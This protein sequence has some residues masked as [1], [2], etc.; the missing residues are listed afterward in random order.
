MAYPKKHH[1]GNQEPQPATGL[2]A[3]R[4]WL[5]SLENILNNSLSSEEQVRSLA[6][7]PDQN[8]N[9]ILRIN[10]DGLLVYANKAS[11]ILLDHM[12][13]EPGQKVTGLLRMACGQA[14]SANQCHIFTA[15]AGGRNYYLQMCPVQGETYYNL[16]GMD[17]TELFQARRELQKE[18]DFSNA[19]VQHAGSLVMVLD[20][21]GR[22]VR[23]NKA[24]ENL[25]GY[26][27]EDV[28]GM[29]FRDIFPAKDSSCHFLGMLEN[30]RAGREF[31]HCEDEWETRTGDRR[32]IEWTNTVI[33]GADGQADFF[34]CV[35]ADITE[36]RRA[37]N[38]RM[39]EERTLAAMSGDVPAGVTAASLGIQSLR[40]AA[41]ELFQSLAEAFAG[42]LDL[43]VEALIFRTSPGVP[44]EVGRISEKLGGLRAGPR[45]AMD[46]FLAALNSKCAGAPPEK[47]RAYQEEGRIMLIELL[48]RLA[49]YYRNHCS[50][51]RPEATRPSRVRREGRP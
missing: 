24:C 31:G 18:R 30:S 35:G 43:A 45:D 34:I 12:D 44:Q 19:V 40:K 26:S 23:F 29:S 22:I 37:E 6:Q 13:L 39:R 32:Q 38:T 47:A 5:A 28:N 9:P 7:F 1:P 50:A 48:G 16:Y 42:I 14:V 8:P 17:I 2:D 10:S 41:P 33:Q 36:R 49:S 25:S 46:I 3:N 21:S 51:V 11:H 20:R 4:G 27:F 15:E